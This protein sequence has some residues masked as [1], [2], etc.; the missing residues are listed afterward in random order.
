M[1][2][3]KPFLTPEERERLNCPVPSVTS[4]NAGPLRVVRDG[5]A[6][7]QHDGLM[8]DRL[9]EVD[10]GRTFARQ[11]G[12]CIRYCQ[13]AGGWF[14]WDGKR[15]KLDDDGAIYRLAEDC[16]SKIADA[17]SSIPDLEERKKV[18]TFAINLRKR[19]GIENVV[20]IAAWQEGISVGNPERFDAE[21]WALNVENGTIDLHGGQ[22]RPHER[23]D[24]IT[25][26][27]PIEYVPDARCERWEKFLVEIFAG[28]KETIDFVQRAVGYSL[29][30]SIREHV[31]L[32]LFGTGA[33]GKTTLLSL[34]RQILGD[35]GTTSSPETF[36]GR[37]DGGASND[38][39]RLRG[40]RFVFTIE[41]AEGKA[42]DE[43]FVKA[44]TG[45]DT[46][47]A[48][49]LY[50]EFFEF[51]PTFKLWMATNHKPVIRGGDEGIWRRVRLVP[52]DRRFEGERADA[53]L[54]SKLE[55]E[56]PGILA[57]AVRGCLAWQKHGL[58]A[59]PAI[60]TA[61]AAY[62]SEMDTFSG[63]IDDKCEVAPTAS[64]TAAE[65]YLA[66]KSWADASAE[67]PLSQR[68]FG[69]RLAERGFQKTRVGH[70]R[71]WSGI[72]LTQKDDG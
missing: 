11:Y 58:G 9:A 64:A 40:A 57:W 30:G 38:R 39:A 10:A 13:K 26:V 44:A 36:V 49:F 45:G 33:N 35:Y 24:L 5:D 70:Q 37:E 22:L 62:R 1:N 47:S 50:S 21:P 25:K 31:F 43:A 56:L 52:F 71:R 42:L 61:T 72:G 34:V 2:N 19:R 29:T 55:A 53:D 16:T 66:Y 67:K 41:T 15:W 27:V 60:T 3:M 32:V 48:R 7:P 12:D 59:S 4:Q 65:L 18:L 14:V 63:F 68:W 28:D 6:V 23:D 51:D 8:L 46:I 17:A 20:A 54:R 69:L